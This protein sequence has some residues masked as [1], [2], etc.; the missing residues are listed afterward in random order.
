IGYFT[1]EKNPILKDHALKVLSDPYSYKKSTVRAMLDYAM[2]LPL[3]DAA[4]SVRKMI[5]DDNR[6]FL[7][8]TVQTLGKIGSSED[9]K[10]LVGYMS[11]EIEGDEKTRLIIRQNVMTAIGELKCSEIAP[12][13][14]EIARDEDENTV[15]RATAGVAA[16]KLLDSNAIP[17]LV[18]FFSNTDPILR[19]AAINGLSNFDTPEARSILMEGIKDS[20]Y[21]VRLDSIDAVTRAKM[22]ESVDFL[23]FRARTDPVEQVRIKAIESLAIFGGSAS[24]DWLVESFKDEKATDKVRVRIASSLLEKNPALLMADFNKVILGTLKDDKKKELRYAFGKLITEKNVADS[25]PIAIAYLSHKDTLTKSIGLDMY[26]KFKFPGVT[27]IVEGIA[28]DDKM[29][30]LQRRAKKILGITDVSK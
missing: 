19:S 5:E 22:D 15:I 30:A 14:I 2:R 9:A 4:P 28:K 3:M 26:E 1:D 17:A 6:D 20:H 16:G 24:N 27:E 29:G 23:L 11:G 18:D 21:K 8:K 13:L 7:D 10:Y 12:D 25:E